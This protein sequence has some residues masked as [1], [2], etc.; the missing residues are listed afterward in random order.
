M[1]PVSAIMNHVWN[2]YLGCASLP[3]ILRLP[4]FEKVTNSTPKKQ[5]MATIW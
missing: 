3:P 5:I 2:G 4:V 1:P